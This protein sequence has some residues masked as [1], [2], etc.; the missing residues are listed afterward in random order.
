M[1]NDAGTKKEAPPY[2]DRYV[3]LIDIMGWSST[4]KRSETDDAARAAVH[5]AARAVSRIPEFAANVNAIEFPKDDN[6]PPSDIRVSYFSDTVVVSLPITDTAQFF[7]TAILRDLC[8]VLL[9][10]GHYMRGAIVRGLVHHSERALYGPAVVDAHSLECRTAV[11]PRVLITP[12]AAKAFADEHD[13]RT[14]VDGL[15]YLNILHSS[16]PSQAYIAWLTERRAFVAK[17]EKTDVGNLHLVA[18]HR[19]F[20]NYVST[21]LREAKKLDAKADE[22]SFSEVI[23]KALSYTEKQL[24]Q[25]GEAEEKDEPPVGGADD[26]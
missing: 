24:A 19:W 25:A 6:F 1:A 11:Y 9:N 21:V 18:K 14:D 22:P 7:L 15:K 4:L 17:K 16:A 5:R 3:A 13:I 26:R 23:S 2:D 20:K 10:D 12:A 8:E